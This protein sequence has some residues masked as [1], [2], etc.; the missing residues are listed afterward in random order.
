MRASFSAKLLSVFS[1][2]AVSQFALMAADEDRS[3]DINK[4]IP[5]TDSRIKGTPDPP[6]PY[7]TTV[8]FPNLKFEEPLAMTSAPGTDRLFVVERY[9][10]VRS[11]PNQRDVR[12]ADVLLDLGKE[13]PIYGLAFHPQFAANGYFYITY[14]V[15]PSKETLRGT[16]VSR[17]QVHRGDRLKA[18]S[19]SEQV[20][21]EW[22]SGGHNGG[23]LKFGPDGYLYIGTGDSSGIADQLL[24]GQDISNVSGAI[25][26]IDVDEAKE[27]NAYAIPSDNPFVANDE[28]RGEIWAYGLRQPWKFSFDRANGDLW[29]GNV[30]QDLWE[31]VFL[32]ERGGNYGWSVMEGSHPFRPERPRGP[33]SFVAPVAE[34][35]HAEFRSITGGFVYHG[36]KLPEL[37]GA[38]IYGDYDTG[39]IWMLRYDRQSKRVSDHRELFD[40]TLRLVG[41]AEDHHGEL[42]LVDHMRGLIFE[43]ETNPNVGRQADFPRKLSDTGLFASTKDHQPAAGVI[44]Y[45]VSAPQWTD[46]A[47]KER[48]LALPGESKIEFDGITYPQPAPGAPHGWKFPDGTVAIETLS[49]ELAPGKPRRLETRILHYEQLAGGEDVGDQFWR[50]YTYVWNDEQTDAI[51][52]EDPL[53]KDQAFTI[54][55]ASAPNGKRRQTWHFPSRT[56]CTV[57]HNMAAKYVLGI[58]T[59]QTNRDHDYG[60]LTVNQ[61]ETFQHLGL[62]TD[63]LPSDPIDLPKLVD[64]R[65]SSHDLNQRARSYLHANCS[66]C[67]RKWGGGN[68]EFLL[69]GTVELEE[70]GISNVKPAHGGFYIPGANVLTP[71]DPYRSVLFYRAA[72]LGPGR[73][74]RTGSSVVDEVGLKLLHDWIAQLPKDTHVD[75]AAPSGS[76][77][78]ARLSTTNSALQLMQSLTGSSDQALRAQV[79]AR[80]S[81]Q[82]A[83]IRDLFERFLPE[84]QRTKRLGSVIRPEAILAMKGDAERGKAVFF[85]TSGVQCKSCHKIGGVGTE[86]G[87]DLSQ[88]G[89]KYD[90]AKILEN[91]LQPSKEIDPK[92]RVHLVQTVSGQV[93]SGLLINNEPREFV[94]KDAKGK[95]ISIPSADV[96]Q[97]APQ[98]QSMMPDLLLRDLTAEQ[99]ADL[100][101]YLSLLK[102]S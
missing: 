31:Q 54:Q 94:L 46:G 5:W 1:V 93:H 33:S 16:R 63:K 85:Q 41:F 61:I 71:G 32:I 47:T 25:L 22:R 44:P 45:S 42:Y 67:H 60:N 51:L 36:S 40:S 14:H 38:Y 82:P 18:D 58:N 65:H 19:N 73:M 53:G 56:E 97:M 59:L 8:A 12:Q 79:L 2:A 52:L 48:F 70:M 66:H 9:G 30:G 92:Y 99:V 98:Q 75:P 86:I 50:G 81:E 11:F 84:E 91:I 74:P 49:L 20:I 6:P 69:L 13:K 27:A 17:F 4:R 34:H 76:K 7:R 100:I 39:K 24:T 43:L 57:C 64:Y 95:L 28:A 55:D 26:R 78:D 83:H 21:F 88:I 29:T 90:R 68:G 96:E 89:K 62:F 77:L 37:K 15:D 3:F 87:P 102:A 72:K 35:D 10:K 101:T 23:C 80:V